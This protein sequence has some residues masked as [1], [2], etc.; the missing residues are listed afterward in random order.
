MEGGRIIEA[1]L[2]EIKTN[3]DKTV[4][5]LE[6]EISP[7]NI[8]RIGKM[9]SEAASRGVAVSIKEYAEQQDVVE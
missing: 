4:K 3:L 5:D 1:V 2:E 9:L 7:E 8:T 6:R